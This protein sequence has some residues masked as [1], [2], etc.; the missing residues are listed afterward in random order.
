MHTDAQS[1]LLDVDYEC[2]DHESHGTHKRKSSE[3]V[4][5]VVAQPIHSEIATLSQRGINLVHPPLSF[6]V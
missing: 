3:D 1:H 2:D 6:C 4:V 5:Q